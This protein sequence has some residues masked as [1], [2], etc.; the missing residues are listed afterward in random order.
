VLIGRGQDKAIQ[1]DVPTFVPVAGRVAAGHHPVF[2]L[3]GARGN[4][5]MLYGHGPYLAA[6]SSSPPSRGARGLRNVLISQRARQAAKL[7]P[8]VV[9]RAAEVQVQARRVATKTG[10]R[11]SVFVWYSA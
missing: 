8:R 4:E 6:P 5:D 11:R 7:R 2:G 1:S 3:V 10:I 9:C